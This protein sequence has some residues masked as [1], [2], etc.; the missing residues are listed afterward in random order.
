MG[1]GDRRWRDLMPLP[2][3]QVENGDHRFELSEGAKR[4]LV[5]RVDNAVRVNNIIDSLNEMAG[6]DRCSSQK[7]S[8][9]HK[10]AHQQLLSSVAQSPRSVTHVQLREAVHELLHHGLLSYGTGEEAR[11]TVRSF[12]KGSVSLPESG[13]QVFQAK[14]LLDDAGRVILE[15]PFTHLFRP[16]VELDKKCQPYMDVILKN[17]QGMYEEFVRDLWSRGMLTFGQE[18]RATITPFFVIKKNGR[19][20]LVLDCR[21]ANEFFTEPPDIAMAAGYSFS[22]LHLDQESKVYTAQSDIK[23]YFYSIGLPPF[24]SK[25]FCLPPVRTAALLEE[26]PELKQ[27]AGASEVFPQMKVVPMGWSWSMF[28]AQRIH[29]HQVFLGTGLSHE[30]VL[31][32]GR[33]APSLSTGQ[34]VVVPYADNL[35]VIGTCQ[36]EV[37]RVKN[38]AVARLRDVG[39]RI[40]EEED[41][42]LKVKA[43]GFVIDGEKGMI[44]PSSEKR[45]K[46]IA[47]LR[48]MSRRPKVSG[49]SVER[50]LGHCV[51][52]FMLR[53]ELLSIFRSM[54]DFKTSN[55]NKTVKLWKTAAQECR[56]ASDLL[57]ICYSD[58]AKPCSSELTVSDACLTGTACCAMEVQP[59]TMKEIAATREL[60]RYKGKS[61]AVKAR[62]VVTRLDPFT[63]L[64]TALSPEKLV[65]PYSLNHEFANIP[66]EIA[67]SDDWRLQF[68]TRMH[69]K[70]HIT[71]LEGRATVQSI[72][73]KLRSTKNFGKRHV[74]LGDNLGMVL[75]FDRGRA[76]SVPLL[77]CCRRAAAYSFASGCLFHH[78]WL[79]SEWN[80]ADGASR[81]WEDSRNKERLSKAEIK[82]ATSELIYPTGS[83]RGTNALRRWELQDGHPSPQRSHFARDAPISDH[84]QH[85]ADAEDGTGERSRRK[86]EGQTASSGAC[87][88]HHTFSGTDTIGSCGSYSQNSLGL[89]EEG[90]HIQKLLQSTAPVNHHPSQ[91]DNALTTFL[92]QAFDEG[93]DISEAQRY[94]AS[95]MEAFPTVS[96]QSWSRSKRALKGWANLDSGQVRTPLAWPLVSLIALNMMEMKEVRFALCILLMFTT[97][98]RTGEAM[99]LRN[100]DLVR[101][102]TLGQMWAININPSEEGQTSKVGSLDESILLDSP[103]MPYLGPA[104]Q[105]IAVGTPQA[106]LF[107]Q[108][109]QHLTRVW[110]QALVRLGLSPNYATL[111]QLRHS[112]AS[113]DRLKRLRTTLEVK[114]R[115][116]WASD[117]SLKRYDSHAK[118]AQLYEK[119][120]VAIKRSAEASPELLKGMVSASSSPPFTMA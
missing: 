37:Q 94:L 85:G 17:D 40:H 35:N 74:H 56:W 77:I 112:G 80:Q 6:F 13:A 30:Q 28:F 102:T 118:I 119:L 10:A 117:S 16:E 71:L 29:Q 100:Q 81:K 1:H 47:V 52:F 53:R 113:W 105:T 22:Q 39:F 107:P 18:H 75:A 76:K 96:R 95:V 69:K 62:E 26:I 48:W 5:R 12:H 93:V 63:D 59:E 88:P 60:W 43:L 4:R 98:I 20:R 103:I 41:A 104:L 106:L 111:H 83:T 114:M 45:D 9:A 120:P 15:D 87:H 3:I 19:L 78:R 92:N 82:M 51:H 24:L 31:V 86:E 2:H 21:R 110:K 67:N 7:P 44:H 61:H 14:D 46:L 64:R 79:P 73:H 8:K 109:Y 36:H 97:Y 27:F 68:S 84:S 11:S 50:V 34:V 115:G 38:L 55:Y 99:K 101:S 108:G 70:E 66:F 91:A 23:D 25:Y 90:R 57:F 116:R 72:R 32:D 58:L 49:R 65:D 42:Q 54:Y 33:P 89:P